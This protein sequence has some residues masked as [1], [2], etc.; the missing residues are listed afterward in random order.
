MIENDSDTADD[1]NNSE[2]DEE[3]NYW[4]CLLDEWKSNCWQFRVSRQQNRVK[5][6]LCQWT[7]PEQTLSRHSQ[8]K[9]NGGENKGTI[10]QMEKSG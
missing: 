8:R 2:G 7:N 4:L 6:I 1:D 10:T 3:S 5:L 9:K